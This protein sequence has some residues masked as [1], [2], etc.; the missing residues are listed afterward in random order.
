SVVDPVLR[1]WASGKDAIPSYQAG[2]W[3]PPE[4]TRL[5]EKLEQRWRHSLDPEQEEA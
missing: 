2:S 3:G 1:A 5:F 4:S